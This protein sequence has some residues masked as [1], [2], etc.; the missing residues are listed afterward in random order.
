MGNLPEC[1][2]CAAMFTTFIVG[3][4]KARS[5]DGSDAH[6]YDC[7]VGNRFYKKKP[8]NRTCVRGENSYTN[9]HCV[10]KKKFL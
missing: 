2:V 1:Y 6:S 7:D 4:G 8:F 3:K 9:I 10:Y 5:L